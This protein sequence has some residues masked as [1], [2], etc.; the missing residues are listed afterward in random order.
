MRKVALSRPGAMQMLASAG[1]MAFIGLGPTLYISLYPPH[2]W[3][4]FLYGLPALFMILGGA[5]LVVNYCI[6]F[7]RYGASKGYSTWLGLCLLLANV[8]GFLALLL[9]PDRETAVQIESNAEK[10]EHAELSI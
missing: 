2:E 7:L 9:L 8:P 6:G 5:I 10:R 4:M 1:L 3:Q